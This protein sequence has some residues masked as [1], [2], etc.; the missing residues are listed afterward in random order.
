MQRQG[1]HLWLQYNGCDLRGYSAH[2]S[3]KVSKQV[4]LDEDYHYVG[5]LSKTH[6][7]LKRVSLGNTAVSLGAAPL[8]IEYANASLPSRIGLAISFAFFGLLTTGA[9]HWMTT[10]Y[11]HE[12][13]YTASNQNL[14]VKTVNLVGLPKWTEFNINDVQPLPWSRPVATFMAKGKFYY[15]DVYSFADAE[16]LKKLTPD[17]IPAGYKDDDDN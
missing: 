8:I 15:I 1:C 7:L 10:P 12:L 2:F 17:D 6:R 11:V 13:F 4:T 16:L 14:R 3:S 9:L 5:P